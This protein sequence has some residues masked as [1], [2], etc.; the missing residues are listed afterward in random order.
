MLM[1]SNKYRKILFFWS[2]IAGLALI[3]YYLTSTAE[4]STQTT[5]TSLES[6]PTLRTHVPVKNLVHNGVV[7]SDSPDGRSDGQ[8]LPPDENMLKGPLGNP[9]P[10]QLN[11]L[12]NFTITNELKMVT[13]E[14]YVMGDEVAQRY[15]QSIMS[16]ILE[17]TM[18]YPLQ[19]RA[20]LNSMGKPIIKNVLKFVEDDDLV[21][22]SLLLEMME[23]P[24][25]FID[26]LKQKHSVVTENLPDY[27]PNY[28]SGDGYVIYSEKEVWLSLLTVETLR[29]VGAK[30]PIE[31]IVPTFEDFNKNFCK[32]L[33]SLNAKCVIVEQVLGESFAEE[34]VIT[35]NQLK[36]LALIVSSFENVLLLESDVFPVGNPDSFFASKIFLKNKMITWPDY[37]RRTTSPKLYEIQGKSIGHRVRHLN[38][39]WTPSELYKLPE[40]DED[41]TVLREQVPFHD[42]EGTMIDFST[43]QGEML[44]SKRH[45]FKTM[46]LALWYHKD[47]PMGFYPLLSQGAVGEQSGKECFVAASNALNK[48]NYQVF[49]KPDKVYGYMYHGEISDSGLIQ[50]DPV[51]DFDHVQT[52]Q[53]HN[54]GGEDYSYTSA[55]TDLIQIEHAKPL[56]Y[57]INKHHMF[58]DRMLELG[59]LF[60][61]N[62][63]QHVRNMG[64]DWPRFNFDLE[65]F[66]WQH[67]NSDICVQG[68]G[69]L[70]EKTKE[71]L[72]GEFIKE[73]LHF[74][75]LSGY[76]ALKL[77]LKETPFINLERMEYDA[78]ESDTLLK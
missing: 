33:E 3:T 6:H 61:G 20:Q 70:P 49:K 73:H 68:L 65:K 42:R 23:F 67:I 34:F 18:T 10:A 15:L 46:F 71:H 53:Q 47:G 27:V 11:K 32:R 17:N 37:Y 59:A 30:L 8:L 5:F 35:K 14:Q 22:E 13:P 78:D 41:E 44:I 36:P 7:G 57:H 64:G 9:M 75:E 28:Y 76:E 72:C 38:D 60:T 24:D 66:I 55:V 69:V 56:F 26:D 62:R 58:P 48:K 45:H 12:Y 77:Y 43:E 1:N 50:Y 40:E 31:V 51:V 52:V 74:L 4:V 54:L 29:K 16:I 19:E 25:E 63:K 21:S 39:E 2:A